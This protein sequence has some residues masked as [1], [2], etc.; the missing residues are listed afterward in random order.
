MGRMKRG[1]GKAAALAPAELRKM[2]RIPARA[3]AAAQR[4]RVLLVPELARLREQ[5]LNFL[6][7]AVAGRNMGSVG[8]R[9][10]GRRRLRRTASRSSS[11]TGRA[12]PMPVTSRT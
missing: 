9:C 1:R 6:K 12:F 10:G 11:V 7:V 5:A 3:T 4:R 2:G 8:A